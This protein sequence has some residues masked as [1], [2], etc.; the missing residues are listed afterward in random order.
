MELRLCTFV[1]KACTSFVA[2]GP[3]VQSR[4]EEARYLFLHI[5]L[6][7]NLYME[8]KTNINIYLFVSLCKS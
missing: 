5:N 4:E 2:E 1:A 6:K 7:F 3:G 8:K